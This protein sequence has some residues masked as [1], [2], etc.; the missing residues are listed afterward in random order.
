MSKS[1]PRVAPRSRF[2]P[3]TIVIVFAA[4]C[5]ALVFTPVLASITSSV[6]TPSARPGGGTT[7]PTSSMDMRVDVLAQGNPMLGTTQGNGIFTGSLLGT[8]NP[9]VPVGTTYTWNQTGSALWT[10]ATNWTPTRTTPAVDDVLVFNNGGTITVTGVPSQ[11]IG[12]LSVSGNTTVNLQA[13]SAVTLNISGG[14]T[15]L[16]VAAGSALNC[17]ANNAISIGLAAG[18]TGSISGSM[19]FSA[20][21]VNTTHN[22][23]A[24]SASGI[25][26]NS[27]AVFTQ[28][29]RNTGNV[30]GSGTSNSVVFASGST[31]IQKD[32]SNPFQKGQPASVVVFQTGS[33]FSHQ[34]SNTPSFSGRTY[35]NFELNIPGAISPSGGSAVVMDNLTITSGTLN[36]GMTATPGHAIK[37]NISV[38]PGQTLNFNPSSA[39]TLN[40]NGAAAQ[41]ISGTGTLTTNNNQTFNINNANGISLQKDLTINGGL[42]LTAG[43]ITSASNTLTIS[44][45]GSVTRTSGHIIGN[46]QKA[47]SAAGSKT[48]EVG[49]ANGYSP[50]TINA[51]VGTFPANVTVKAT[52]GAQPAFPNP[53][54]ALQRYWSLAA[55]GVTADLTFNYLVSDVPGTANENSF[56]IFKYN[57][58]FT[59][60]GGTV[61]AAT[62]TAT[63]SG[64]SSFSDWTC[65]EPL[66]GPVP[67][68]PTPLTTN[69]GTATSESVSAMDADG[70]V[71]SASITSPPVSGITLEDIVPAPTNNTAL[72]ATLKVAASTAPGTYNVTIQY[73]NND[74]T[75]ETAVC[76][77]VVNVINQQIS[78]NCPSPLV[79]PVGT[80]T[81]EGVS[82]TDPDGTITS[83]TITS[84][85]VAGITLDN[86]VPSSGNNTPATAT[87]NV[88]D[89]TAYGTYNVTIQYSNNDSPTPQTATCTVVVTVQPPPPP[90]NNVV[91][92]QI[93]G[94]GGNT[95]ATL[96]NDYIELINHSGSPVSLN[97]WSVQAFVSTTSSWQMTP[98][99]NFTLQPGQYFLIQESQ[100]EGGTDELPEPD[101]FGTITVSSSSTKVALVN[102]TTLITASCPN[103]GAAGIVDL[104]GYGPT[105]CYEGSPAPAVSNTSALFRLNGGCFDTNNNALD[106]ALNDPNPRN[107]SSPFNDCTGLPAFGSANPTSVVAGSSTTLTVHVAPAQDPPSTGITV[108]ADLSQIG[109]SAMQVFSGGPSTFTFTATVPS[110]NPTGLMSLP[111]TVA[112]D[113]SR[114]GNTSITV[115]V[116]PVVPDHVTISQLCG[117][118]GNSG[119]TYNHDY[120]ELYNPH[121]TPFDLTGW[122]VQ[123]GSA[124]GSTWQ[125]QPLG[126]TIAPGE[127]YLVGLATN[128]SSVGTALP[129]ANVNGDINMSAS[130][131]KI[132]LVNNFDA[133]TGPCPISAPG[134]VDFVGYGGANCSEGPTAP[135]LN[136]STADFRKNGGI[137]DT[138]N[139][140]ADFITGGPN[141]R[142]TAPIVEIGPSVFSTDPRDG[143]NTAPRDATI[144]ISFTEPV[145]VDSG[146]Y[147]INCVSTG[148]HNSATVRSFFGGDT[149]TVTPNVNF[150]AGEQC[151]V[152]IFKN[153]IHDVDSDDTGT[154]A[155]TLPANKVFSFTVATGT[156]PPY[157]S[158]VHLTMGNPSGANLVDQN[159]YLMDKPEF[160]V[161]YNRSRGIPNWVSSHLSDDWVGTLARVDT[162]R[163]DPAVPD[164]WYRVSAFDYVGSGFDR[165][166]MVPNAD[167]DKQTSV[168]I[169]QATFLMTN[170][171]PQAPDNNQGPWANLEGYLRTLLP[172]NEIYI[173]A[174]GAG[175][176]GTGSAGTANTIAG[177][178]VTVPAQTWKV[179]LII[180]KAS[181]DDVARVDCSTRTLAVIMPN[182]QG[183]RNDDWHDYLTTVDQVEALT[184]YDFFS[185]LP[186]AV[187]N[188]IEAGTDGTNPP[189]TANQLAGTTEDAPVQITLNAARSN[190]HTLTFSIVSGPTNGSLGSVSAA[191]CTGGSCTATVTYT[192]GADYSGPDSFTFRASDGAI[193]SNTSTVSI[194]VLPDQ[195]G[196]GVTDANDNC[197][198]TA[199]PDQADSD[200]DGIGDVC[201]NCPFAA[202]SNQADDDGDGIGN[203]CDSDDDN[204]GVTDTIDLCP[205]TP[206]GTQVNASGCPD[207]DGDGVADTTDNCPTIAN[208]DQLDTDHDGI[209]NACD[210]DD[211][212]DGILD[213]QDNCPLNANP[214]Q[215]DFD[216]D[217]IGDACDPI[218]GPPV[219]K[220][221]CKNGGWQRFN[222]P[223]FP[224]QGQCVAYVNAHN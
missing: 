82:A 218:T 39:G 191:S 222:A 33:L 152:T 76:T 59:Q 77:V 41:V 157:P 19:T 190:S 110:G 181:G 121:S 160:T 57:G 169:N 85:P 9:P 104:V 179:A 36:W 30:F 38:A 51:T 34:T 16:S 3:L 117:G 50:A 56:A 93:Y 165:G 142:R 73:S 86:F 136:S 60:P 212:N 185:N 195:D 18:T 203:P 125:V 4:L 71:T 135:A 214:D 199:N 175:T 103:A 162:F 49:T 105:D 144:V 219:N 43:N 220:D 84:A 154:N 153:A 25:T 131:G 24:V 150:L 6:G 81:S 156:A 130:T 62:H 91:I 94:G 216:Q 26:F 22:L 192:P 183:I 114:A 35:A 209:G 2:L 120:V 198:S 184:G 223:T 224:N 213:A 92:S 141:P 164:D 7:T 8:V 116:I 20:P 206:S 65:A 63:I 106:F 158:S 55:T 100:G 139:N 70:T 172:A 97:G 182:T 10:T 132:A 188:C 140:S 215:A 129:P 167:R 201:D 171:I 95:G 21:T 200:S 46:L 217:G 137:T 15:G 66:G 31:F 102:N 23:T 11:T 196:D 204:D 118:G 79:T 64:V 143:A 166:H 128:N 147:D 87:L 113:Q 13:A 32:G 194:T 221:Q 45:T 108:T 90:P 168:P 72:T 177:G 208:A 210:A 187:E 111:V 17:N 197:P 48:F 5:A 54:K 99:P 44:S 145:T 1:T 159:N 67:N 53:A 170:M 119:A 133:L 42:T 78:P 68:C 88:A 122:S 58:T 126:G 178:N 14:G 155:D 161:S 83:A 189:G 12:Q 193:Q 28:G 163:A 98:L 80:A 112:D 69:Q 176:G 186:D 101:A 37:G 180:P 29:I 127:Y 40:L 148:T 107:S 47:Y 138:D 202:N 61:S 134:L 27:G 52:Q 207:A 205:N 75:P 174:G 149:F 123:Y 124:T 89:T 151:T 211:D 109:G 74:P 146:W 173:V 115:K 96:T